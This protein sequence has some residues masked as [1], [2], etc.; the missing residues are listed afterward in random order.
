LGGPAPVAGGHGGSLSPYRGGVG[1]GR[2]GSL[3]RSHSSPT[4]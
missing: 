3:G 4:S 2:S 1:G